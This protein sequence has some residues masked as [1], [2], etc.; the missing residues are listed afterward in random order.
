M[1]LCMHICVHVSIC[2]CVHMHPCVCMYVCIC[3]GGC[4]YVCVHAY[5]CICVFVC[6]CAYVCVCVSLFRGGLT[7]CY[8]GLGLIGKSYILQDRIT[9]R[10]RLCQGKPSLSF[11]S[12]PCV[13]ALSFFSVPRVTPETEWM[14][15]PH[16][17][18]FRK[19]RVINPT[20][21]FINDSALGVLL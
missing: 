10:S 8:T 5:M 7:F 15:A 4:A 18:A 13:P 1:C 21:F 16:S 6:M 11:S 19:G 20:P 17:R 3:V 2:A 12:Y 14:P 9:L